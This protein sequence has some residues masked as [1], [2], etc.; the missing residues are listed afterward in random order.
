MYKTS[1]RNLQHVKSHRYELILYL[2]TTVQERF[3]FFV[4]I[5]HHTRW[6]TSPLNTHTVKCTRYVF[7]NSPSKNILIFLISL[8][9]SQRHPL[10]SFM[11]CIWLSLF[12]LSICIYI[13]F[14]VNFKIIIKSFWHFIRDILQF[15]T[16]DMFF[17]HYFI[18]KQKWEW[19][20]E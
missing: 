4:H 13:A 3:T 8:C 1:V 15:E 2:L 10:K 9:Q 19:R 7:N 11:Q 16:W 6:Q 14:W 12:F 20:H 5:Y 17:F 18:I